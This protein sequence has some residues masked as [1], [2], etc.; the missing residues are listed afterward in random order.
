LPFPADTGDDVNENSIVTMLHYRSFRELFMGDSGES[1]EARL[2]SSGV[3]L[4][5][6]NASERMPVLCA[7]RSLKLTNRVRHFAAHLS[8]VD[9]ERTAL[10]DSDSDR[11]FVAMLR[12]LR[13]A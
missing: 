2:L 9:C 6:P 13:F 8:H 12:S 1:S 10:T 11:K 3:N 7:R 5:R 4:R